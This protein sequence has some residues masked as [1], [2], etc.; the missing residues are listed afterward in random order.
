M[1]KM[2]VTG[3][4]V[5]GF[6]LSDDKKTGYLTVVSTVFKNKTK[7]SIWICT[8]LKDKLLETYQA[9]PIKGGINL[10]GSFD[11]SSYTDNTGNLQPRVCV[12]ADWME[13]NE[14]Y[15]SGLLRVTLTKM[16][17][18]EDLRGTND[19]R[20]AKGVY[21]YTTVDKALWCDLSFWSDIAS[22]AESMKLK[23]GST[24]DVD[25]TFDV[26]VNKKDGKQY[27]NVLLS[28]K[29]LS[30]AALPPKAKD[31]TASATPAAAPAEKPS[32]V[33]NEAP[34]SNQP[35]PSTDNSVE[36]ETPV[37]ETTLT[38]EISENSFF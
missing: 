20:Y 15:G 31:D 24:F 8:I 35:A 26:E 13:A 1:R 18:S 12:V 37:N 21:N 36:Q 14:A 10:G 11:V 33:T 7:H 19:V 22:R 17:L 9:N 32:T 3:A 25:A 34:A 4:Q 27:L 23:K 30:Y 6:K 2:E 5:K 38:E 16:R 28:V 29:D